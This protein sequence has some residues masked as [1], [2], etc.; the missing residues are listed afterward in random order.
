MTPTPL[1]EI[2]DNIIAELIGLGVDARYSI[3][4]S[5]DYEFTLSK[6]TGSITFK[7]QKVID[8]LTWLLQSENVHDIALILYHS[9]VDDVQNALRLKQ[10]EEKAEGE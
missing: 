3:L 2:A 1:I 5:C 10:D 7:Y 9:F 6:V 8:P 4:P